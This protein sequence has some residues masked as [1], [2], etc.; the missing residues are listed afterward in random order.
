MKN[1][2]E[3]LTKVSELEKENAQLRS[4]LKKFEEALH[5]TLSSNEDRLAA[6]DEC[7]RKIIAIKKALTQKTYNIIHINFAYSL[8]SQLGMIIQSLQQDAVILRDGV[9]N[10]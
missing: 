1:T 4:D 2:V 8:I 10:V 6:L 5:W 7:E 3:L 9:H